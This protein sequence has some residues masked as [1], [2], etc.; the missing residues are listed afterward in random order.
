MK[1]VET[2]LEGLIELYPTV[3]GDARGYFLESF[4]ESLFQELGLQSD[5]VQD[6]ESFSV[7]GTLRGLHF[8]KPPFA[9]GKLVRVITGKVLD[10][11]LDIRPNSK[12]FGQ[13][14]TVVLNAEDRN[15]MYIPPGF[16]HG[17]AALEDSIFYYKCTDYY[18]K[19]SEAGVLWNDPALNI[20]WEIEHPIIS[21]KDALLPTFEALIA[22]PA[23]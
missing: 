9:Q 19:A 2:G 7:K 23:F 14:H 12:T 5:F 15:Q 11:V 22:N 21:E 20:D 13:H 17:F 18:N 4:R 1:V 8:Q 6:N 16:A 10:V 3:Y